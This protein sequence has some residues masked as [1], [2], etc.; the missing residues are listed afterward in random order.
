MKE[1]EERREG[2]GEQ[3][4]AGE[5]EDRQTERNRDRQQRRKERMAGFYRNQRLGEGK[6]SPWAGEG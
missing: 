6:G 3:R 5:E 2:Q 1:A 4:E